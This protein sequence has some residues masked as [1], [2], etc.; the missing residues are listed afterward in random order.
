LT[1]A[2]APGASAASRSARISASARA[3]P[4]RLTIATRPCSLQR[5]GR[6]R[7]GEPQHALDQRRRQRLG[8][9]RRRAAVGRQA[10]LGVRH[11]EARVRRG[12][13]EVA[14][15]REREPGARRRAFDR[16]DDRL[17]IAG[18]RLDPV[19]QVVEHAPLRRFAGS[20]PLDQALDVAAGAE[21]P[22]RALAGRRSAL[23]G[24]ASATPSASIAAAMTC[25]DSV[26]RVA[27]R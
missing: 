2:T 4:G 24:S 13:D 5:R 6:H 21:V 23:S 17:R 8:E 3:L 18:H 10:E 12:D 9:A 19:V 22:A 27:G 1:L 16:G 15:E 20:A 7:L 25:A 14:A 26:L 11:D